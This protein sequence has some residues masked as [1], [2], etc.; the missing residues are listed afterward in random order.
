MIGRTVMYMPMPSLPNSLASTIFTRNSINSPAKARPARINVPFKKCSSRYLLYFPSF[1]ITTSSLYVYDKL[2][3]NYLSNCIFRCT[4][5][6]IMFNLCE[7]NCYIPFLHRKFIH[8][9]SFGS[10]NLH[11]ENKRPNE[12]ADC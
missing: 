10:R 9:L 2:D 7:K 5:S 3:T 4:S 12:P 1:F 8:F 11:R 6:C